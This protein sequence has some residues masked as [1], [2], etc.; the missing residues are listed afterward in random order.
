MRRGDGGRYP[1]PWTWDDVRADN[2]MW[3][4]L[5]AMSEREERSILRLA[6]T[7]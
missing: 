3:E 4:A 5:L 6:L 2:L 1:S 7:L